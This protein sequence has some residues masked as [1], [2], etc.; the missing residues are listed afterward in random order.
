MIWIIAV[1]II[2]PILILTIVFVGF[3]R[4]GS[5]ATS[6]SLGTAFS[7]AIYDVSDEVANWIA[8]CD[9]KGNG[10][11]VLKLSREKADQ[12]LFANEAE[13]VPEG[14]REV[15][16]DTYCVYVYINQFKRSDTKKEPLGKAEVKDKTLKI[17]YN[18]SYKFEDELLDYELSEISAIG[19]KTNKLEIFIDGEQVEYSLSELD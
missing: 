10:V 5:Y 4:L 2:I 15:P 13:E 1:A 17:E 11:Y 18:P 14:D 16:K 9:S 7:L 8:Q 6:S 12:L 19:Y 3:I